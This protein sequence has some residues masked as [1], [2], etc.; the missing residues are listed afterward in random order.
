MESLQREDVIVEDPR[1]VVQKEK[2]QTI[3]KILYQEKAINNNALRELQDLKE[4]NVEDGVDNSKKL[5]IVVAMVAKENL[6]MERED[7]TE[8]GEVKEISKVK[9]KGFKMDNKEGH[10]VLEEMLIAEK[11]MKADLIAQ[12]DL[13]RVEKTKKEDLTAQEGLGKVEKVRRGDH[14]AQEELAKVEK[15]RRGDHIAQEG[16]VKVERMRKEDLTDQEEMA[17]SASTEAAVVKSVSTEA[18]EVKA[19]GTEA[20]VVKAASTE[21]IV[22]TEEDMVKVKEE[23]QEVEMEARTHMLQSQ[24]EIRSTELKAFRV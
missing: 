21:A 18:V 6:R 23:A 3:L 19:A 20:V 1:L 2:V 11:D 4:S 8:E 14:I 7:K 13:A 17:K 16:L 24:P 10:T 5:E 12:E 9:V 15:V 22:E